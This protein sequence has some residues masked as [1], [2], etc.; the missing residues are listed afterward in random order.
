MVR[1]AAKRAVIVRPADSRLF[2]QAIFIVAEEGGQAMS[3]S[4]LLQ[5]AQRIA[6][7]Y[8]PRQAKHKSP[9]PALTFAAGM[10]VTGLLWLVAFFLL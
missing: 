1:G 7:C 5:E 3:Q 8:A 6:G 10:G 4:D 2:E 9:R